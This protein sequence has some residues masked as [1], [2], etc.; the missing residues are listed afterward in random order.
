MAAPSNPGEKNE[1]SPHQQ[2]GDL[3]GDVSV[4]DA[5]LVEYCNNTETCKHVIRSVNNAI[6]V[7]AYQNLRTVTSRINVQKAR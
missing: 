5:I 4:K 3:F 2:K 7:L 1:T 6:K